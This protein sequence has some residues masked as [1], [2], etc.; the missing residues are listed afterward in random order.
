MLVKPDILLTRAI[1]APAGAELERIYTLHKL[2]E[3]ADP[4]QLLRQVGP[5]IRA[6]VTPG[7]TGFTREQLDALPKLEIIAMFGSNS[8]LD[9]APARERGIPV[10]NTPDSISEGVADLAL[11]LMIA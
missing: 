10:T 8:T 11:G 4:A 6:L 9:L 3:V 1:Y 2:G 7:I 5:R